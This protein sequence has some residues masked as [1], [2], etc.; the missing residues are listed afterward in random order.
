VQLLRSPTNVDHPHDERALAP[1]HPNFHL[2]IKPRGIIDAR[3]VHSLDS[4][5]TE[6]SSQVVQLFVKKDGQ[7]GRRNTTDV[8]DEHEFNAL[9]T[10]VE[11]RLGELADQIV[12]GDIR[13]APYWISRQT[14][15]PRCEYRSVCRFEPGINRYNILPGMKREEVLTKVTIR[16]QET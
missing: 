5:L 9:L 1:D 2:R 16:G 8:A 7:P 13:V 12:T 15:C 3:A 14:P 6:G 11:R 4:G 10:H